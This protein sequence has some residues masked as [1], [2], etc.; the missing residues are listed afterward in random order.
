MS[1]LGRLRR[2]TRNF[3]SRGFG[4]GSDAPPVV[5]TT[6]GCIVSAVAVPASMR[7]SVRPAAVIVPSFEPVAIIE[8][9]YRVP[10]SMRS[11]VR[12]A[13]VIV[14]RVVAC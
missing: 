9:G 6:Q 4:P 12:P 2:L 8:A 3:I 5:P 10:A 14:P 1:F 11:F 13:A 7:A